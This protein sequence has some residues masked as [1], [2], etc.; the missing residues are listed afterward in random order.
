MSKNLI[1]LQNK[2]LGHGETVYDVLAKL[3]EAQGFVGDE[4]I[5]RIAQ[6]H[7][8]PPQ[9]VR[10]V[11]K[12][13]EELRHDTPAKHTVKL[14]NGEACRCAGFEE[15]ER[16][17]QAR[18]G[19]S[20]PGEVSSKG[21]RL[22]HITCLGLCGL[23]PN[24]MVDGHVASLADAKAMDVVVAHC[25]ANEG[26]SSNGHGAKPLDL[27]TPSNALHFP[28]AGKP[29][30]V[31]RNMRSDVRGLAAA[32]KAGVYS[33]LERVL[34]NCESPTSVREQI[35]TSSLRGRG[36]AGF[37]AGI[38]L[39][40]VANAAAPA[41]GAFADCKFVVVN[42]DEGDAGSYIDKEIM[43]R[44]PH[45][46][47]EGALLAAY[48]CGAQTVWFYVRFEYPESVAT[49]A[50]AIE[51]ANAAGLGG[52]NI[53]GTGFSCELKLKKGQGAYICGE[54]TSLLRSI[55]GVPAIVSFKPP[56]PAEKGLWGCPTAVNN[57][58]TLH[59]L[60]WILSNGGE[61]YAKL[62]FGRSRGTKAVTLNSRVKRP[63]MYEVELGA[64]LRDVIFGLAG[65]MADG[66]TFKAVQ[67]GGPLGGIF[68]ES[69]L[70]T[71]LDFEAMSKAKGLLGHGGIV[72]YSDKDD[73]AKIGR[74]LMEFCAIESCGK[75]FPC[76][77][78]AVRGTEL[79]E[80]IIEIRDTGVA[81]SPTTTVGTVTGDEDPSAVK[82]RQKLALLG[83]LCETMKYGSLCALGGAIPTPIESLLE[84]FPHEF[85]Q[86]Q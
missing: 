31:M 82:H 45:S 16:A 49:M 67:V 29:C 55:E 72:V 22:E 78:G 26:A 37:P 64:T 4:D 83:E 18:L 44:D 76:R 66:H 62:G 63:G 12:F 75:C 50:R 30:I 28:L 7:Q 51:D 53:L 56:F 74:W 71:P 70:D 58:E 33:A 52:R 11:A 77:I 68:P 21:V 38:K 48:A 1:A 32:R 60:P 40:T 23:G 59:N 47:I 86:R 81:K 79:I 35:K 25:H 15:R 5:M 24:V 6:D 73:L 54:E 20:M 42:A 39:D 8:L 41:E 19:V 43:E 61:A 3:R 14:C 85:A 69:L 27:P 9:H 84:H 46:L 2:F 57:V 17:L 65:G 10:S 36:G 34:K 13:Y 80:Q